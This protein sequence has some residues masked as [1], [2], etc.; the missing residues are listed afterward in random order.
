MTV[1]WFLAIA[2]NTPTIKPEMKQCLLYWLCHKDIAFMQEV[3]S[4]T[5]KLEFIS[6]FLIVWLVFGLQSR[7]VGHWYFSV[8]WKKTANF[9][10][11][12]I[13]KMISSLSVSMRSPSFLTNLILFSSISNKIVSKTSIHRTVDVALS[14]YFCVCQQYCQWL[15]R[16]HRRDLY[17]DLCRLCNFCQWR[18]V[19]QSLFH[20]SASWFCWNGW[21]NTMCSRFVDHHS[22]TRF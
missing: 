4:L 1:V 12:S 20:W 13:P 21:Q 10:F 3:E 7:S 9:Q 22:D 19:L 11:S 18:A 16:C 2:I 6:L 14:S 17:L 15:C 5:T 8:L